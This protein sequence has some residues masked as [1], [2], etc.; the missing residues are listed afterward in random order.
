MFSKISPEKAGIPS[1][2]IANFINTLNSYN[3]NTHSIIMAK[4]NNIIAE[5]YYEPFGKD[6]L[7]RMY[8]VSKSFVAIA[9]GLAEQEGLLSLDDKFIDYFP[10]Y[11]NEN[12]DKKYQETTI[13]DMLT[14]RSCMAKYSPWW[15]TNDRA[16]AYFKV[17]SN[18]IPGTN[19]YYDSSGSFILGCII[20]K[21][22]GMPYLEYLKEKVLL[23]IGFSE[24]SYC[25]LAP[26]GNSHS[27]SGV[28]CTPRDLLT[29]ARFVMNKGVWNG[30]RYINEEFMKAAISKQTDNDITATPSPLYDKNGY[31]YLIWKMPRDGF[32]FIGMADQLAICDPKTD[33]IFVMTGE[34]MMCDDVSK[35]IILHELYKN[36]IEKID[37]PLPENAEEYNS[38]CRLLENQKIISLT[39]SLKDNISSNV[40]GEKYILEENQ[41]GIKSLKLELNGD[42][43]ILEFEKDN[44]LRK[45]EF[46]IGFNKFGKFPE[47]KRIGLTASVYE[48][49]SYVCGASAKWC[50]ENKLHILVRVLDTYLGTLSIVLGF[51]DNGV[52]LTMRKFAQRILDDYEGT[53]SGYIE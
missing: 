9:I 44:K 39:D 46:G 36:I 34:N 6:I 25:L 12:I 38:L 14:M 8:S 21:V 40:T 26:G 11:Q 7:H 13:R 5:S 18:Q 19:F 35:T 31:G 37:K 52:T 47:D 48:E 23:K 24:E 45:I 43:G 33:F 15:E 29:F 30:K 16:K 53:V 50:E 3:I 4:G 17:T 28:M 20:E 32:G 51:K 27:D 2:N 10:E 22:T 42:S 41:M 49:G 1:K